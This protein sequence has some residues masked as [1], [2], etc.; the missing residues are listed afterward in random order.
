[1]STTCGKSMST[2]RAAVHQQ[3]KRGQVTV[4][5]AIAVRISKA[6]TS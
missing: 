4:R 6:P 1:M 2:H 3:V 5:Q